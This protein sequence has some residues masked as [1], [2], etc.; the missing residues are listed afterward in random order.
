VSAH[1]DIEELADAAGGLLDA[2][3]TRAVEAHVQQCAECRETW[4]ALSSVGELLAAEPSPTMP[5]AVAQRLEG[6]L[7]EETRHRGMVAR[8]DEGRPSNGR[9]HGGSVGAIGSHSY[10][11]PSLGAF[12]VQLPRRSRPRLLASVVAACAAAGI[13]GFGGYVVSASAGLNEP[14]ATAPAV[15]SS[16]R[17]GMQARTIQEN[18]D[19]SPHRFSDAWE[20]AREVTSGRITAITSAVVDGQPALLVYTRSGADSQVAVV[21]GCNVGEPAAGPSTTLPR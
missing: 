16:A 15:V 12:A 3:A 1:L 11:K 19:L 7:A 10:A 18:A 6:V 13:V 2:Q 14:A 4:R 21:T 8:S 9:P 20:C 5:P 17:L